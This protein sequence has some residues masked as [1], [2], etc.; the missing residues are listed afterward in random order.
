MHLPE[1]VIIPYVV[2]VVVEELYGLLVEPA[3][4]LVSKAAGGVGGLPDLAGHH[5]AHPRQA[6]GDQEQEEQGTHP[7]DE[8]SCS[9]SLP[10]SYRLLRSWCYTV[11]VSRETEAVSVVWR[12]EPEQWRPGLWLAILTSPHRYDPFT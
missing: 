9:C 7:P 12:P 10:H 4:G 2:V 3:L 8:P 11:A 5:E 6:R 1:R